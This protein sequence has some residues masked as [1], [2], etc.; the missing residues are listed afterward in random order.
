VEFY[1]I[2]YLV[3]RLLSS[4]RFLEIGKAVGP[5]AT[6][7][8]AL[9]ALFLGEYRA[10]WAVREARQREDSLRAQDHERDA[11]MRVIEVLNEIDSLVVMAANSDKVSN[12]LAV[13]RAQVQQLHDHELRSRLS[14]V[15]EIIEW[16]RLVIPQIGGPEHSVVLGSTDWA[17]LELG[18]WLRHE[19]VSEAPVNSAVLGIYEFIQRNPDRAVRSGSVENE[20]LLSFMEIKGWPDEMI[21][22]DVSAGDVAMF[23]APSRNRARYKALD[24]QREENESSK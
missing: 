23:L 24:K 4:S 7:T 10:Q 8:V 22:A 9:A 17:R 5:F 20:V 21:T 12:T 15:A 13:L 18:R 16:R 19:R 6:A 14:M 1:L 2:P 3:F 11:A